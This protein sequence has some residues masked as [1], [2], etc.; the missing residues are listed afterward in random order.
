MV[1]YSDVGLTY[2]LGTKDWRD[3]FDVVIVKSNKPEFFRGHQP[4][5]CTNTRFSQDEAWQFITGFEPGKVYQG[6]N[7][8]DFSKWTGFSGYDWLLIWQKP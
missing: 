1:N 5:R 4:F 6:G 7:L 2:I 8:A 3:L